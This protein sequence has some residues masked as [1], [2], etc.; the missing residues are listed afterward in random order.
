MTKRTSE[1]EL[2]RQFE[3]IAKF[4]LPQDVVER[5]IERVRQ[6]LTENEETAATTGQRLWHDLATRHWTRYVSA[7]AACLVLALVVHHFSNT[8]LSAAELLTRVAQNLNKS[9][10]TRVIVRKYLPDQAEPA[11]VDTKWIDLAGRKVYA[12]YDETYIHLMDYEKMHWSIYNPKSREMLI[13]K[14]HGQWAGPGTQL[15]EYAKK[16]RERGL[17]VAESEEQRDGVTM[18][19]IEFDEVLNNMSTDPNQFRSKMLFAG[20]TVKTIRTRLVV[21][22]ANLRL[23]ESE[24]Q[25]FAADDTPIIT[26][27]SETAPLETGPADIYELGVPRD[28]MIINKV[29]DARVEETRAKIAAHRDGFLKHYVAVQTEARVEEGQERIIE[30]MVIYQQD[31]K[32]RVDVFWNL[33]GTPNELTNQ[34]AGIL[35]TSLAHAKSF[36]PNP[37]R[38]GIRSVRIYDGLWQ[39]MLD[40]H[41]GQMVLRTP[42]RRPDGDMYADDDI[43]DFGWRMLWWLGEP[44]HMYDNDFARE[45]GL[46]AMELTAP[47]MTHQLPKRLALYVDPA[48]DYLYRRYSEEERADAPWRVDTTGSDSAQSYEGRRE[49]VR[50]YDVIEYGQTSAGQWYPRVVTIEGYEQ[51]VG[52]PDTR[53]PDRRISRIHLLEEDPDL[54]PE[55]FDP[56]QLDR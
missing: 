3:E 24:T 6:S 5:D 51:K 12:I 26:M 34:W 17:E 40:E 32:L 23:A 56:N 7:A 44:E 19:V 2:M 14:L 43:E 25:Y 8:R 41:E 21:D 1:Q 35:G 39:H 9:A 10:W 46:L 22:R 16:L 11:S 33:H 42:Q 54:P 18:T 37:E 27:K 55:L 20:K 38:H 31:E 53:Q 28:V 36:W 48:K 49:R 52:R 29:P 50:V 47:G 4:E 45:H 13:Q 30:T 15:T